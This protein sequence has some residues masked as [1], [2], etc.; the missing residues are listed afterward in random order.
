M[1][2]TGSFSV[3]GPVDE[4]VKNQADVFVFSSWLLWELFFS[5]RG[6]LVPVA[7]DI[8]LNLENIEIALFERRF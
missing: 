8:I 1:Q 6:Y 4:R 7:S 3:P 5:F 2:T